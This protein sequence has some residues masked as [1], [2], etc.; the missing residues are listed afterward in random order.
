[1]NWLKRFGRKKK[2]KVP[3]KKKRE[4]KKWM[5]QKKKNDCV[6]KEKCRLFT[7]LPLVFLF[8]CVY[9]Y[10]IWGGGEAAATLA[11][12]RP[13]HDLHFF[14]SKDVKP[15]LMCVTPSG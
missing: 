4:N 12:P 8:T 2:S 9:L 6:G 14:S 3:I 15:P 1:M 13:Q 7:S 11:Y 5:G 10:G